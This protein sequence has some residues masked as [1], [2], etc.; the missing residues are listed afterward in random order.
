MNKEL[1]RAII[2][3]ILNNE[4]EFQLTNSTVNQF[5][6]YIYDDKGDYLIGGNEVHDWICTM[7]PLLIK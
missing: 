4:K 3:N 6:A 2:N 5:R 7:I 1:K